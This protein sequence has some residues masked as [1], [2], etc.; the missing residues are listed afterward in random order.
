[1]N[2]GKASS[3]ESKRTSKKQNKTKQKTEQGQEGWNK[4]CIH[5]TTLRNRG[6]ENSSQV[7]ATETVIKDDA[8]EGC[9]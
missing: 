6:G 1:V 9:D 5:H 4:K 3:R 8:V 7:G 2:T